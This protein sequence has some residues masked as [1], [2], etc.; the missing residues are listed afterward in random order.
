M[1][2]EIINRRNFL[3]SAGVGLCG[4]VMASIVS[5]CD[6]DEEIEVPSAPN[7]DEYPSVQISSF[8]ELGQVG[9]IIKQPFESQNGN[10]VNSGNA[11]IIYRK[12][13]SEFVTMDSICNHRGVAVNIPSSPDGAITCPLHGA[14]FSKDDGTITSNGSTDGG[15]PPIA[16]FKNS[17]DSSTGTLLIQVN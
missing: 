13:E 14:Q 17:F 11:I 10:P 2:K 3:K 16:V 15:F 1:G 7:P 5:S 4:C 6:W 9:G 12:S 8:P